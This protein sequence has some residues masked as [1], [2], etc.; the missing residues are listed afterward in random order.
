M[1]EIPI[2]FTIFTSQSGPLNKAISIGLDGKLVKVAQGNMSSGIAQ[3]VKLTDWRQLALGITRLIPENALALG[4]LR[5]GLDD[6]AYLTT[7][8]NRRELSLPGRFARVK[9]NIVYAEG[10]PAFVAIDF[11]TA[12]MP[13]DVRGRIAQ[14]GG[15]IEAVASI[16]QGLDGAAYVSRGSTSSGLTCAATGEPI[17]GGGE[18]HFVVLSDGSMA[19]RFLDDLFDRAWIAGMGWI[20]IGAGGQLL[21]R[22][23]ID[24]CVWDPIRLVFEADATL[25]PGLIQA[26]RPAIIHE[27]GMLVCPTTLSVDEVFLASDLVSLATKAAGPAGRRQRKIWGAPRI[28]AMVANGTPRPIAERTIREWSKGDLYPD[29]I[30]AFTKPETVWVTVR[31]ILANPMKYDGWICDHPI[32]SDYIANGKFYAGSCRIFTHGHGGQTFRLHSIGE[33]LS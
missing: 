29:A 24:R 19:Q 13:D 4:R 1:D 27:G 15:P 30:I 16:C 14:H 31:E 21:K 2:E 11:D 28:E 32:E 7:A 20:Q 18:H 23:I 26:P 3:R 6:L 10:I 17:G 22:S 5:P 9:G 25:G 12:G 33:A 8:G